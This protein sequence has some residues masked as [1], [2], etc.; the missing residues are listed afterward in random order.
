[1]NAAIDR[2]QREPGPDR[3]A[4]L[5]RDLAGP[6]VDPAA[7][8]V[9]DDEQQ[10]HLLGDRRRTAGCRAGSP[11][12]VRHERPWGHA[13]YPLARGQAEQPARGRCERCD[14]PAPSPSSP[15][16][17]APCSWSPPSPAGCTT[18]W[19][20][21]PVDARD[22]RVRGRQRPGARHRARRDGRRRGARATDEP[23]RRSPSPR[24]PRCRSS[25]TPQAARAARV[26]Q[27]ARQRAPGDRAPRARAPR[28]SQCDSQHDLITYVGRAPR[29][30][31]HRRRGRRDAA[32]RDGI[33]LLAGRRAAAVRGDRT[34]AGRR[35]ADGAGA[36]GQRAHA[37]DRAPAAAAA[38]ALDGGDAGVGGAGRA[39]RRRGAARRCPRWRCRSRSRSASSGRWPRGG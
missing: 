37:R 1:M 3:A 29:R 6:G 32:G 28:D 39:R 12:W 26:P 13:P 20:A 38:V 9:P 25:R 31:L 5:P 4:D 17:P 15:P 30:R 22:R 27:L 34:R 14:L 21:T 8:D 16:S 11:S 36:R 23:R 10:Q 33:R 2:G 24:P 35:A 19:P 18:L 7:E